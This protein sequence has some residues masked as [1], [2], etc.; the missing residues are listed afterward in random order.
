MARNYSVTVTD[1]ASNCSISDTISIPGYKD[2]FASFFIN[3]GKCISILDGSF[4]FIDNSNVNISEISPASFWNF[5]DS[6]STPYV[7]GNNPEHNYTDTGN[8]I[9]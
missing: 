5:G 2:I 6:S 3:R 9:W 7:F 8:Y 4:Q 1:N